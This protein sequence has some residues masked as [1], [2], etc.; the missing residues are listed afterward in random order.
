MRA[1]QTRFATTGVLAASFLLIATACASNSEGPVPS[2]SAAASSSASSADGAGPAELDLATAASGP[3]SC[4]KDGNY[5]V[6]YA[7][8]T[9]TT[10]AMGQLISDFAFYDASGTRVQTDSRFQEY[11]A[12]NQ[13]Y[14][15]RH[16]IAAA[17]GATSGKVTEVRW[18]EAE[19]INTT[20]PQE[21]SEGISLPVS[22]ATVGACKESYE[23]KNIQCAVKVTN[24]SAKSGDVSVKAAFNDKQ[25]VRVASETRQERSVGAGETFTLQFFG[26]KSGQARVDIL[27]VLVRND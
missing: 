9:N 25:G 10:S 4:A 20:G 24:S 16:S 12:P 13:T 3:P 22:V 6:C 15:A 19:T 17:D 8:I 26:P 1:N 21:T 27:E 5:F 2:S 23:P 11:V 7:P 14:L 18:S